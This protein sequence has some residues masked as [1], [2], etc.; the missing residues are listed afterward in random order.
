M[1]WVTLLAAKMFVTSLVIMILS[2][3]YEKMWPKKTA[4]AIIGVA[5]MGFVIISIL[6]GVWSF[7]L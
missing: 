6:L 7:G 1:N 3:F 2:S 5:A 4:I